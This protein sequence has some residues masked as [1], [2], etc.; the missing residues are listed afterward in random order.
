MKA[1]M[2]EV[3]KSRVI[4]NST[5][6]SVER[7]FREHETGIAGEALL[8]SIDWFYGRPNWN[9]CAKAREFL[10]HHKIEATETVN[11][12]KDRVEISGVMD[13]LKRVQSI[14]T[15]NRGKILRL[16]WEGQNPTGAQV[17]A[18]TIGPSGFLRAPTIIVGKKML[19]GFSEELYGELL[20]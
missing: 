13:L 8:S 3:G 20:S 5:A 1:P 15:A 11:A 7:R 4:F 14:S 16:E 9:T 19:V 18:S 10:A 2:V 6:R 12:R 17:S